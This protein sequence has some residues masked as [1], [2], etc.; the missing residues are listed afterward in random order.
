MFG[1]F[2]RK[3]KDDVPIVGASTSMPVGKPYMIVVAEFTH[4]VGEDYDLLL[5][6]MRQVWERNQARATSAEAE[7]LCRRFIADI[8]TARERGRE[9]MHETNNILKGY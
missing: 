4:R 5:V 6:G 7:T 1:W 8:D 2:I 9:A 3:P